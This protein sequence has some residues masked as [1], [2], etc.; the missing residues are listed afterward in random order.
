[1]ARMSTVQPMAAPVVLPHK[2]TLGLL[3]LSTQAA[4]LGSLIQWSAHEAQIT[5]FGLCQETAFLEWALGLFAQSN[6]LGSLASMTQKTVFGKCH[7]AVLTSSQKFFLGS[8]A[9]SFW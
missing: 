7:D 6:R 3:A 4:T 1:M 2:S 8:T 9:G 5:A